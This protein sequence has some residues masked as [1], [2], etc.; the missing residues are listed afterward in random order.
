MEPSPLHFSLHYWWSQTTK[1]SVS[2]SALHASFLKQPF[3]LISC[4]SLFFLYS[5]IYKEINFL[6]SLVWIKFLGWCHI[7]E[8]LSNI[9][10]E[11][12]KYSMVKILIHGNN[13][14][15]LCLDTMFRRIDFGKRN[16][17]WNRCR[18]LRKV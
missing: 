9:M 13:R 18:C 10:L 11:G 17:E 1:S 5:H 15:L 2:Q 3:F 4:H 8:S 14:C 7:M 6:I 16:L 12:I